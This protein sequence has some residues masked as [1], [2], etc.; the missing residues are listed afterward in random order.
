MV[1]LQQT[2]EDLRLQDELGEQKYHENT[3]EKFEPM[4]EAI[5]IT[6]ENLTKTIRETSIK[7]NKAM[8]NLNEVF[9]N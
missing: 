3:K 1:L 6:S 2:V 4:T 8:E 9:L 5:K 7:N